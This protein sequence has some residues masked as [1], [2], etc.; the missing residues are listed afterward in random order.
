MQHRRPPRPARSHELP[1]WEQLPQ[2]LLY[3]MHAPVLLASAALALFSVLAALPG[4]VGSIMLGIT[5]LA[6]YGYGFEVLRRSAQGN[7]APPEQAGEL[8]DGGVLRLVA[9]MALC[10]ATLICCTLLFGPW[11][12]LGLSAL[13]FVLHPVWLI[14]LALDGSLR[15]ALNPAT[16]VLTLQRI[17]GP[18]AISLLLVGVLQFAALFLYAL[19]HRGL[20]GVLAWPLSTFGYAMALAASFRLLGVMVYC[21][22]DVLGLEADSSHELAA[23]LPDPA[24]RADQA[25]LAR[26]ERLLQENRQ[27]TARQLLLQAVTSAPAGNAVHQQLHQLLASATPAQRQAHLGQWLGQ[28]LARQQARQALALWRNELA[29]DHGFA[30]EP[31]T[32]GE[33]LVQAALLQGQRQLAYDGLRALLKR[34]PQSAQ[35]APWA[36]QAALLAAD[37]HGDVAAA[38]RLIAQGQAAQPSADLQ[39]RLQAALDSL[40]TSL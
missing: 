6:T 8:L 5:W 40:P 7:P 15:Q 30:P 14:S 38:R 12:M 32:T 35:V 19:A 36:L 26:V 16:A 37:L 10:L 33:Q 29:R 21:Y 13:L 27:D 22:R 4:L 20:P 34:W 23:R 17:A 1:F 39:R 24:E 9:L 18:Y 25:L 11:A 3:P 28:L 31:A 2:V